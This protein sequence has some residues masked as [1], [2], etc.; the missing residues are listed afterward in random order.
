MVADFFPQS[1]VHLL[2]VLVFVVLANP[3]SVAH[4]FLFPGEIGVRLAG[5]MSF[6][7]SA[8]PAVPQYT[9]LYYNMNKVYFNTCSL[10]KYQQGSISIP[11]RALELYQYEYI[12][13]QC[14]SVHYHYS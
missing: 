2:L 7:N 10:Y 3:V 4:A 13:S 6:V 12:N 14:Y 9:L 5:R 11:R 8:P 1:A